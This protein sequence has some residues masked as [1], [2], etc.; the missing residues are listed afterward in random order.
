MIEWQWA[1]LSGLSSVDTLTMLQLRQAV[2]ILEQT[3]LY[4]DIDEHDHH[5]WHL[6]GKQHG[7]LVA[8]ARVLAPG[9]KYAETA[10][11]RVLT[12]PDSRG[13]GLGKILVS[14]AIRRAQQTFPDAGVRISAQLYLL[15]FYR[16]FG[17]KDTSQPY[18]EDG[19]PHIEMH[20]K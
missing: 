19:I 13:S 12:A 15:D 16:A 2:F 17:F 10:M 6:L 11:G 7:Q 1:Q 9:D 3:C 18:D 4:P 20:L 8:Y 5:A 14:E